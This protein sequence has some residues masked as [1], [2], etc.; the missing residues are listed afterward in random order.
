MN[1]ISPIQFVEQMDGPHGNSHHVAQLGKQNISQEKKKKKKIH[2][3]LYIFPYIMVPPWN[4]HG[5][6]KTAL[7]L[8]L[9]KSTNPKT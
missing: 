7:I 5:V 1:N 9:G 4:G 6:P 2:G 8:F 3:P